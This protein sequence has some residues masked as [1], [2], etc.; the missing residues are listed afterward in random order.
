MQ[1]PLGV[2]GLILLPKLQLCNWSLE[3]QFCFLSSLDFV[4]EYLLKYFETI[5]ENIHSS[6]E[7]Y[8]SSQI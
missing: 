4:L 6:E 5:L 8:K 1:K 3:K 7:L 2:K